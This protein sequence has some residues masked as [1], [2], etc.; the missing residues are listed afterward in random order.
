M[1]E[2]PQE[3]IDAYLPKAL[4]LVGYTPMEP[5]SF[6]R[7][8][9]NAQPLYN[10]ITDPGPT[11]EQTASAL[12]LINDTA[13]LFQNYGLT[14]QTLDGDELSGYSF[15]DL[16]KLASYSQDGQYVYPTYDPLQGTGD[17]IQQRGTFNAPAQNLFNTL[18]YTNSNYGQT[19]SSDAFKEIRDYVPGSNG[20][21]QDGY[22]YGLVP[23]G[24]EGTGES[25]VKLQD[26]GDG[27]YKVVG[28]TYWDELPESDNTLGILGT[29]LSFVPGLQPLGMALSAM[30]AMENDNPLGFMLSAVGAGGAASGALPGGLS[31]TIGS[32]LT[33]S[34]ST[35]LLSQVLG[36]AV[37]GGLSAASSGNALAG[38]LTGGASAGVGNLVGN[39]TDSQ[40]AGK[41][42]GAGTSYL[43]SDLLKDSPEGALNAISNSANTAPSAGS[44]T[45]TNTGGTTSTTADPEEYKSLFSRPTYSNPWSLQ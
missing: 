20:K 17:A 21:Q 32:A 34:A 44:T 35:D 39:A 31:G 38:A 29:V 41:L 25:W 22:L 30:N 3:F 43:L 16:L 11:S 10:L 5:A 13:G 15:D 23:G 28:S 18:N 1:T 45:S 9:D 26:V 14:P 36:S 8:A 24:H 40:L 12:Q 27:Q 37:T 42:A 33:G 19:V 7:G 4:D 2:L 6:G